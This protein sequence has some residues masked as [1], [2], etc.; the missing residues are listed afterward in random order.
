MTCVC[1]GDIRK[2]LQK[3]DSESSVK[4][5]TGDHSFRIRA[6]QDP[7]SEPWAANNNGQQPTS[8]SNNDKGE[9][10]VDPIVAEKQGNKPFLV[11]WK[12]YTASDDTWQ[13]RE[14][15][16][17]CAALDCWLAK[18][19]ESILDERKTASAK[20]PFLVRW[21]GCGPES[22]TW[23]SREVLS[24]S[25]ALDNWLIPASAQSEYEADRAKTVGRNQVS[26]CMP[27]AMQA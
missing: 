26:V 2:F 4:N 20:K 25:A 17:D 7:T 27:S 8:A 3:G 18:K 5:R 22:D 13:T 12:G 14:S 24:G 10:E 1:A 15:L 6:V 16:K 21:E 23:E 9:L 11:R 19:P